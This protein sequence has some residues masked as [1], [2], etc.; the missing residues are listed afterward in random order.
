LEK[1]VNNDILHYNKYEY[2]HTPIDIVSKVALYLGES[3]AYH[4]LAS[5]AVCVCSDAEVF[6]CQAHLT[7]LIRMHKEAHCIQCHLDLRTC[8]NE[9]GANRFHH[10]GPFVVKFQDCSFLED[11]LK[12]VAN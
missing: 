5:V 8:T 4:V 6:A 11:K 3:T 7:P 1:E 12:F 2:C 10:I 9:H